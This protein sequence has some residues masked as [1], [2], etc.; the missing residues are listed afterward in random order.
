MVWAD[1]ENSV[2]GG[3]GGGGGRGGAGG[4]YKVFLVINVFH[5][6]QFEPPSRSNW[7]F[8]SNCFLKGVRSSM[9]RGSRL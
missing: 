6:R 9:Y 7:T 5:R 2:R 4:P 1:P 3:G 8:G